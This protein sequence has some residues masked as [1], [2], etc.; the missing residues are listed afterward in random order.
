MSGALAFASHGEGAF[1]DALGFGG[2]IETVEF[3]F[4]GPRNIRD[5]AS[6]LPV[7]AEKL[8]K[9]IQNHEMILRRLIVK[10]QDFLINLNQFEG[11][12]LDA[13]FLH[14]L[15]LNGLGDC[16]AE[17]EDSTGDGPAAFKRRL[18]AADEERTRAGNDYSAD[19]DYGTLGI[20]PVFSHER[21]L[22]G[23]IA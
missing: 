14:K 23:I 12:D 18:G 21:S 6:S 1:D 22:A 16:F 2:E 8:A 20:F 5:I 11:T 19:G 10:A 13:R 4:C 3:V 9:I 17:F 15:A 7:P